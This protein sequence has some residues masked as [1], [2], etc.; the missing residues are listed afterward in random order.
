MEDLEISII[1]ESH[2]NVIKSYGLAS[3][4]S[5]VNILVQN[6]SLSIMK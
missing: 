2:R 1:I 3:L 5:A 6:S 4:P